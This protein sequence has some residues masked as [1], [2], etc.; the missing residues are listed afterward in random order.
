MPQPPQLAGFDVVSTHPEPQSSCPLGQE[1]AP[2]T[3]VTPLLHF[4]AQSPQC[5][6][7]VVRSTH[8]SPPQTA[9][10]PPSTGG[11]AAIQPRTHSFW[12]GVS[13]PPI[14]IDAPQGGA[15]AIFW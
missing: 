14:G 3:Q 1:Q 13:E 8:A 7:L 10:E 6:A 11:S 4:L 9:Q 2:S 15:P 12:A 5:A